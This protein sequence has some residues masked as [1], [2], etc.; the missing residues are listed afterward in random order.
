[1]KK[2]LTFK[3]YLVEGMSSIE[4]INAQ[5]LLQILQNLK[6]LTITEK[7]FGEYFI[8][9][10]EN[11]EFYTAESEDGEKHF[12]VDEYK[13]D[14]YTEKIK[15]AHS[16]LSQ[17]SKFIN[18]AFNSN[19]KLAGS[20]RLISTEE[21]TNLIAL[22]KVIS[23]ETSSS[24][25]DFYRKLPKTISAT[26][27]IATSEDGITV[28]NEPKTVKFKIVL[29]QKVNSSVF[30]IDD[31]VEEFIKYLNTE[32]TVASGL[33]GNKLTNLQTLEDR[34]RDL[35]QERANIKENILSSY[36]IPLKNAILKVKNKSGF[37]FT[38]EELNKEFKVS[39]DEELS[40]DSIVKKSISGISI[41]S[42]ESAPISRRGGLVGEMKARI[43][44]LFEVEGLDNPRKI[45][46]I[47]AKFKGQTP[48]ET[49]LNFA[50]NLKLLS[51]NGTKKKVEAII[52]STIDNLEKLRTDFLER[53]NNTKR[54]EAEIEILVS[55]A[56]Q[57]KILTKQLELIKSCQSM[58][59][60]IAVLFG[61]KIK[62]LH[63]DTIISGEEDDT[64]N[65]DSSKEIPKEETENEEDSD[66][67]FSVKDSKSK[68]D[69]DKELNSKDA[70]K[71]AAPKKDLKINKK[72]KNIELSKGEE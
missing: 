41:S 61:N 8:F 46:K 57:N 9:G 7:F 23:K 11:G 33:L 30:K 42:D 26:T 38:D 16:A 32:N 70:K 68:E 59:K 67:N 39:K 52:S 12:N 60:L 5:E 47:L 48:K 37:V 64:N 31:T 24:I 45:K 4:D 21:N 3:S 69:T 6:S 20:V 55:F 40:D 58:P 53:N 18:E 13:K 44:K 34:S 54:S 62:A 25:E 65:E 63:N 71:T 28:K 49:A 2:K 10:L 56:E 29:P 72:D 1:M 43:H 51:F 14:T 35:T 22:L 27:M 66:N 19:C 15:I 17:Y 50:K 36:K